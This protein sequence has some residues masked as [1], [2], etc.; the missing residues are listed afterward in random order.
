MST[1]IAVVGELRFMAAWLK[2]LGVGLVVVMP[3]GLFVVAV[4]ALTRAVLDGWRRAAAQAGGGQ[5]AVRDVLTQVQFRETWRRVR[6]DWTPHLG[7]ARVSSVP[8]S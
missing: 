1:I 2:V 8:V 6:A 5:V 4:Y 7:A 3:G